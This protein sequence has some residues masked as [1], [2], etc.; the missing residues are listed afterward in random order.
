[1]LCVL[2]AVVEVA[3][4]LV[5]ALALEVLL[6]AQAFLYLALMLQ[7]LVRVEREVHTEQLVLQTATIVL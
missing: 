6:L 4:T 3:E 1:M 2:L 5:V 7:L